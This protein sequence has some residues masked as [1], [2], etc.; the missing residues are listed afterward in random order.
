MTTNLTSLTQAD[1]QC[2]VGSA[3]FQKGM[4]YFSRGAIY[5]TRLQGQ[6][7]KAH[8]RGSQADSYTLQATLGP[9][10]IAS[11]SCS[12]PVG[13]GGRCKHVA[14][15]LLTWV[16]AP[17]FFKAIEDLAAA[18]EAR[19]KAELIALIQQ[20]IQ[21]EPDL[22][23]LLEM[24]HP[25]IDS[26]EKPLDAQIIRRQVEHA[27]RSPNGDWEMGWGDP[28]EIVA[29]LQ[30]LFDLAGQYQAQ[31]SFGHAAT[32][33]RTVA[34]T[35][36]DYEDAVVQDDDNWLGSVIDDCVEGLGE[37]MDSTTDAVQRESILKALF[38]I[39]A[40]D[41]KEGGID[42]GDGVPDIL[43]EQTTPQERQM[44]SGWIR[45]ALHGM[46]DWARQSL[47][48]LL[49]DLQAD[50]M[51]DESF[52]DACRQTGRLNDL[53]D[54]LL[55]LTRID[56]AVRESTAR[57]ATMPCSA[58]PTCSFNTTTGTWQKLISPTGQRPARTPA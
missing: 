56:E 11:A 30:T 39:Y 55:T 49:L 36:L 51:D 23:M 29:E 2:W 53:V 32:I 47:G 12:C 44:I 16:D 1:I 3:S 19:S 22:E 7:L 8:C 20:M 27:F 33:Y 6:T 31:N 18:L 14:A 15:L 57:P 13:A 9:A 5:D 38:D 43:L 4:P 24:P 41:L 17:D 58:W 28:Y 52:L 10:G 34:E 50:E 45:P 48:G 40:W 26:G 54:R 25:G 37:C 46:G 35:V 42:I 21:R